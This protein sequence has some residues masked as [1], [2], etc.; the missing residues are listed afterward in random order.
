M[1]IRNGFVSNS[2]TTS[3]ICDTCHEKFSGMDLSPSECDH[4]SCVNGHIYCHEERLF[5][6]EIDDDEDDY[7]DPPKR[8]PI[9]QM[10][11]ITDDDLLKYLIKD[12]NVYRE[13]LV[14]EIQNRFDKNYNKFVE[15]IKE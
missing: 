3:F 6:E 7:E 5:V 4:H 14:K 2:S 10:K 11:Y 12:S 8:C 15:F 13:E 9:C 1:K